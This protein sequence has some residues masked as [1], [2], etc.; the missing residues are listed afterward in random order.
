MS[1]KSI[2]KNIEF[3]T[4]IYKKLV[5]NCT[6]KPILSQENECSKDAQKVTV[7]LLKS[8]KCGIDGFII[9]LK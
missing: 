2:I 7:E 3:L 4:D 5:V 1:K 8:I 6:V 9:K